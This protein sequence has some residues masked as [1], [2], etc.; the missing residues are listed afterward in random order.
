M[1]AAAVVPASAAPRK[2][3]PQPLVTHWAP[4]GDKLLVGCVHCQ[5]KDHLVVAIRQGEHRVQLQLPRLHGSRREWQ[6]HQ[7]AGGGRCE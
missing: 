5:G 7:G 6:P 4:T 3:L 2:P 1:A